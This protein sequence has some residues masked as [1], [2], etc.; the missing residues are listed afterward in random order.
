MKTKPLL[1]V[2]VGVALVTLPMVTLQMCT[3]K[4]L[5]N[6]FYCQNTLWGFE[7]KP[8]TPQQKAQ[9][10]K[11][12][13]FTGFEG[14]GY[15]DFFELKKELDK[16]GLSMPVNYVELNF[17]TDK[18]LDETSAGEIKEMIKSSPKGSVIYFYLVNESY[19]D[20]KESGDKV[21]V[22]ILRELAD[23]AQ[24]HLAFPANVNSCQLQHHAAHAPGFCQ[25]RWTTRKRNAVVQPTSRMPFSASIPLSRRHWWSAR[26]MS[27]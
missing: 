7:N 8:E 24:F 17:E 12:I 21:I 13:G 3:Q 2:I 27:P 5:N 22:E 4:K 26:V 11:S 10:M 25:L 16:E 6:I 18:K 1:K 19:K 23:Y 9:L 15:D 20:D 14:F